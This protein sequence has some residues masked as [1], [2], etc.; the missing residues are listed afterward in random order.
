M[1]RLHAGWRPA[2]GL[3]VIAHGLAHA[4]LALRGWMDPARF[5]FDFSPMLVYWVVVGGFTIAGLGLLG[6]RWLESW[7]RPALVLASAYSL[8]SMW[9]A[10]SGGLFWGRAFDVVLFLTGITGI[11]RRLPAFE[12]RGHPWRVAFE[13]L[14]VTAAIYGALAVGAWPLHRA[15]GSEPE[16]TVM[17]L[18]G[19]QSGRN[20]GLEVQHAV[21]ID[22]PPEQV[23][24]W[25]VQLGQD[26]AGFYSY[27]WLERAFGVDIR[28]TPELRPE[29][30]SRQAGDLVHATQPN[31][32]G[33]VF[34]EQ[35]GWT[36]TEVQPNRA[37]VLQNWGAFV[38][39]PTAD[40]R[41][42][43]IIRTKV[44][45]TTVRP[46]M[47]ALDMMAFELPHFIMERKMMLRIKALAESSV[48][49]S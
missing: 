49:T 19:D 3:I 21:T 46:W 8:I 14:A 23:W 2:L 41:T 39:E 26:R 15:W 4:V 43:F 34:G 5:D 47:A 25:L 9:V 22:A 29:W 38:L 10:G 18:P 20:R 6:V 42:R 40:G 30:Q 45:D 12:W 35:P 13:S 11:Y 1:G 27:D 7:V 31:Y 16:E 33:G 28:N 17:T 48:S 24:P 44:G 32:L 36:V 37:M